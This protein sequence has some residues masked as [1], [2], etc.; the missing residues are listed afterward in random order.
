LPQAK[1]PVFEVIAKGERFGYN[2]NY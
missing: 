2:C 1:T